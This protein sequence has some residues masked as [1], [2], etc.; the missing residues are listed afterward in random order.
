MQIVSYPNTSQYSQ[1]G[2]S[3]CGLAAMNCVRMVLNSDHEGI[4]EEEILRLIT[5]KD[6]V[7]VCLSFPVNPPD[8]DC[9]L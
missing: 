3:A 1:G 4:R 7:D 5:Q 9:L 6:F 8:F 2:A